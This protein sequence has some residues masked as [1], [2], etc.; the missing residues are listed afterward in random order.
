MMHEYHGDKSPKSEN[1]Y[2]NISNIYYNEF[3]YG[4]SVS[5]V[6]LTFSF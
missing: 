4:T 5:T 6:I 3:V 2:Y 1:S